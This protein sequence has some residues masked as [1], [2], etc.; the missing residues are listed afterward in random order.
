M[1]RSEDD[2]RV[3]GGVV[4]SAIRQRRTSGLPLAVAPVRSRRGNTPGTSQVIDVTLT[5]R[6]ARRGGGQDESV[7]AARLF[8]LPDG[9]EL[10]WH[11]YGQPDGFPVI[12]FH[13]SPGTGHLFAPDAN[14]ASGRGVRLI[15][16]D[17]PGYGHSTYHPSR[18]YRS[19]AEDVRRLAEHLHLDRFGVLG[20]SSG[21]PN[22][23]AC[24][25]FMG[26]RLAGC[27]IVSGPA[28]PEHRVTTQ[29]MALLNRMVR[30][31]APV[32]P[33]L[34]SISWM[35][36][37]RRAQ[38]APE[39]AFEL[40]KRTLPDCDVA[41]MEDP[42]IR[43]AVLEDFARPLSPSAA[44]AATQDFVLELRPWGFRLSDI[45]IHVEVWHGALDRNIPVDSGIYQ[46]DQIPDATLHQLP[47]SGHWYFHER[48]S[49]ILDGVT[50]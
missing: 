17:R 11:E 23:A 50:P 31:A 48:M 6:G 44:R 27:A 7:P 43:R 9:R 4:M 42:R 30:R 21:G 8:D 33:R 1:G 24:A 18:T 22:A 26:D 5:G 15:A 13:G 19:W 29:E 47:D 20:T 25:R 3:A 12:A 34:V 45:S 37:L 35:A 46:A 14:A 49:E 2:H 38:R 10:A 41:V 32:A 39:K 28:P 36:G 16:P 40:M